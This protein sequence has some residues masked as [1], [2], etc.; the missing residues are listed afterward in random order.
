MWLDAGVLMSTAVSRGRRWFYIDNH[1][2]CEIELH[3]FMTRGFRSPAKRN[4]DVS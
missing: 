3:F 4:L 2:E 1:R